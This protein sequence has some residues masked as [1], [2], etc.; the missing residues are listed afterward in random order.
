LL[1]EFVETY[2]NMDE[3]RL[4]RID[5]SFSGIRNRELIRSMRLALPER[6]INVA[7]DGQSATLTAS[8]TYTYVWNRAGFPPTTRAQLNW[9]LQKLGGVWTVVR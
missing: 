6:S 9:R 2:S 1:N 4:R 7:P 5:P 3:A 8:G